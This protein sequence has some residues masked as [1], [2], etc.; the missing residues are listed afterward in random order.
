MTDHPRKEQA[1]YREFEV[2]DLSEAI[3]TWCNESRIFAECVQLKFQEQLSLKLPKI[4]MRS[5]GTRG[6]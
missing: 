4:S 3:Q 6:A 5:L 2:L 1:T